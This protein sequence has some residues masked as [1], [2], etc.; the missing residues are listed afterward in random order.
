VSDSRGAAS[1]RSRIFWSFTILV[2]SWV[3]PPAL[4]HLTQGI[5]TYLDVALHIT[6]DRLESGTAQYIE[7]GREGLGGLEELCGVDC[8]VFGGI[9]VD[10]GEALAAVEVGAAGRECGGHFG[11][12]CGRLTV[13]VRCRCRFMEWWM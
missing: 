12:V 5:G 6:L 7:E 8:V 9:V 10:V 13:S 1:W 2:S 3:P 4:T 11:Y